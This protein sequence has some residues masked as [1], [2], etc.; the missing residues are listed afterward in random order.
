M[1][2]TTNE[3]RAIQY[4][5]LKS[6]R[7]HFYNYKSKETQDRLE[8]VVLVDIKQKH[9]EGSE[10]HKIKPHTVY[11]LIFDDINGT[12]RY[13]LDM[14]KDT[15][16]TSKILNQLHYIA[17]GDFGTLSIAILPPKGGVTV[18]RI[19]ID[20][21]GERLKYSFEE[22]DSNNK[23]Y[24]GM[25]DQDA[26]I[27]TIY[28]KLTGKQ[29]S[30]LNHINHKEKEYTKS[31]KAKVDYSEKIRAIKAKAA[32]SSEVDELETKWRALAPWMKVNN[33]EDK[34]VEVG[35]YFSEL[36]AT[37]FDYQLTFSP[38]G[39]VTSPPAAEEDDDLPF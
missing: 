33:M 12:D 22:F 16:A 19:Y 29:W 3:G 8:D 28:A 35:Q 7:H 17:D 1:G 13:Q 5:S 39:N 31:T 27:A 37:N 6:S 25:E 30:A 21:N 2:F 11:C 4:W 32:A 10:Q 23:C 26:I 38:D 34:L 15:G 9:D 20:N 18:S 24:V 36:A 14:V